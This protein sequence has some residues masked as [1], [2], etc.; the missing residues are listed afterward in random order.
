MSRR[1]QPVRSAESGLCPT[2][3]QAI[4]SR[5]ARDVAPRGKY[6]PLCHHISK[7]ES[8]EWQTSF[9]EIEEI[10]GFRLPDF[11]RLYQAWWANATTDGRSQ[12]LAWSSQRWEMSDVN[13]GA[14]TL[15]FQRIRNFPAS[16]SPSPRAVERGRRSTQGRRTDDFRKA[17]KHA[18]KGLADGIQTD[19]R[20]RYALF[21]VAVN[22]GEQEPREQ[23]FSGQAI[24]HS[25]RDGF[26]V[27]REFRLP[28]GSGT[29]DVAVLD[30]NRLAGGIEIKAPMTNHDGIRNK[31][32]RRQGLPEDAREL[33][34]TRAT[35]AEAA[36]MFA[37]FEVYG[38]SRRQTGAVCRQI[39]SSIRT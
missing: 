13:L 35:G 22:A 18:L 24:R 2:C 26:K 4:S 19:D 39:D 9:R 5:A 37:L 28:G 16:N 3:V 36:E 1:R 6:A 33:R 34:V 31:T 30:D 25:I 27:R 32:R 38:P 7:Q 10:L 12:K 14:E 21:N 15:V 17:V 20:Q 11:A 8:W 23:Q 29:C